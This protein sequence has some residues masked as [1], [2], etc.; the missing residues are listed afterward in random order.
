M[1]DEQLVR[2]FRNDW[3]GWVDWRRANK[4][5]VDFRGVDFRGLQMPSAFLTG[6]D[7]DYAD[8]TGANLEGARLE[9]ASCHHTIFDD[10]ILKKANFVGTNLGHATFKGADLEKAVLAEANLN[11]ACFEDAVLIGANLEKTSMLYTI[12]TRAKLGGARVYGAS[13]WDVTLEGAQQNDLMISQDWGSSIVE[14]PPAL[15]ADNLEVAQFLY[16]ILNNAKLR[17]VIE[18]VTAKLVLILGRFSA[19]SLALLQTLKDD[20]RRRGFVPVLFTFRK[21]DSRDLTETVSLL[22]HMSRFIVADI[23]A[24]RSVPH[25]LASLVPRLLSVRVQPLLAQG[26]KPYATF[27][28]IQRYPQVLPIKRYSDKIDSNVLDDVVAPP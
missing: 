10:A 20:L 7:L 12:F 2:L 14:P 1:A 15:V 8:F 13:V 26:E 24:P 16:L 9:A 6:C 3:Q 19:E 27:E 28:N 21:P 18:T 23:S 25:E 17:N 11:G 22:G 4:V 5:E